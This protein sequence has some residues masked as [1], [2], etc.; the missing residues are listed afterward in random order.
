MRADD[1]PTPRRAGSSGSGIWTNVVPSSR[2]SG[3]M[4][5]EVVLDVP[6]A[7]TD[8]RQD[9]YRNKFAQFHAHMSASRPA[10]NLG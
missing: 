5:L 2:M 4:V 9:N 1:S 10:S 8:A 7:G 6:D 3:I